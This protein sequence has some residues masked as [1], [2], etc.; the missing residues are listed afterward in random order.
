VPKN[1]RGLDIFLNEPKQ[2][3]FKQIQVKN[4]QTE[5]RQNNHQDAITPDELDKRIKPI[6]K[7]I[8]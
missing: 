5:P 6:Y 8:G 2:Q 4:Q 1:I 3:V 7:K